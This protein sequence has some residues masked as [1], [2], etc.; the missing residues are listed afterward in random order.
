MAIA[1]IVR[2]VD[3]NVRQGVLDE[4]G[5]WIQVKCPRIVHMYIAFSHRMRK[6]FFEISQHQ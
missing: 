6:V 3:R 5:K 4:D 1:H 2:Q